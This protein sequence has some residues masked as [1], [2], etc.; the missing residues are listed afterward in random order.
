MNKKDLSIPFNPQD[1]EQQPM[2]AEP[3]IQTYAEIMAY[4]TSVLFLIQIV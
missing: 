4:L 1:T 3:T 2:V